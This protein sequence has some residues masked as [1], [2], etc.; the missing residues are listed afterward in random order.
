MKPQ[1]QQKKTQKMKTSNT[2]CNEEILMEMIE[3]S[4]EQRDFALAAQ[5]LAAKIRDASTRLGYDLDAAC[6]I[7]DDGRIKV[8]ILTVPTVDGEL[9]AE[10]SSLFV[11]LPIEVALYLTANAC[12]GL[13]PQPSAPK[14]P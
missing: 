8:E 12:G 2:M 6:E 4:A 14:R 13:F 3:M 5:K 1:P 7:V 10:C 11:G 9:S